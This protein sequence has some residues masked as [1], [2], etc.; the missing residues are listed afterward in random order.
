MTALSV[1][2]S[3][4]AAH[5]QGL[6]PTYSHS[7]RSELLTS[8]CPSIPRL[9]VPREPQVHDPVTVRGVEEDTPPSRPTPRLQGPLSPQPCITHGAMHVTHDT[10][11]SRR[12]VEGHSRTPFPCMKD[13][14]KGAVVTVVSH[15]TV[16]H[17]YFAHPKGP[18]TFP[19]PTAFHYFLFWVPN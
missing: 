19:S 8:P 7:K 11:P 15:I 4:V 2:S 14:T 9:M 6:Q 13:R 5:I 12:L 3:E 16:F 17:F 18:V 1:T 10:Q